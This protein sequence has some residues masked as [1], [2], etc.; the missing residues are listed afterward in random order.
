M[1]RFSSA[2][3]VLPTAELRGVSQ[4]K[5]AELIE[6]FS[7]KYRKSTLRFSS[8]ILRATPRWG[9][10]RVKQRESTELI[11]LVSKKYKKSTLRFSSAKLRATP[12]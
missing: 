12:R 8:A 6:L 11:E 7:K 2:L 10:H 5:N 4:R 3:N 9:G 1:Y